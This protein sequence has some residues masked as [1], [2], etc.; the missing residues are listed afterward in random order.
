MQIDCKRW[1]E[2]RVSSST[3]S[4][5]AARHRLPAPIVREVTE[6]VI[7]QLRA[8]MEE[9]FDDLARFQFGVGANEKRQEKGETHRNARRSWFPRVRNRWCDVRLV[10]NVTVRLV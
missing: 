8:G 10:E 6:R 1:N 9:G 7:A 3:G 5:S 4:Y 2:D